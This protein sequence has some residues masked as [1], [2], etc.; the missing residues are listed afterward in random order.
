MTAAAKS[1][2][3]IVFLAALVLVVANPRQAAA[4]EREPDD[5]PPSAL[6]VGGLTFAVAGGALQYYGIHRLADSIDEDPGS[7]DL[8]WGFLGSLGGLMAEVGGAMTTAWAW[9][10]GEH[11]LAMDLRNRAPIQ[12]K[13]WLGL[14]GLGV[15]VV[16]IIGITVGQILVFQKTVDCFKHSNGYG[17]EAQTCTSDMLLTATVIQLA[18]DAVLLG[19]AAPMIGYGFG[20]DSAADAAHRKRDT[21]R[22]SLTPGL[23]ATTGPAAA[24]GLRLGG[25]F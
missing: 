23:L 13:R 2:W 11:D 10:L 12:D 18:G 8:K 20:Y 7:A 17:T 14:T 5:G 3:W 6:L 1:P 21:A 4:Q 24:V 19:V 16:G 15:G 9:K 25:R 22:V